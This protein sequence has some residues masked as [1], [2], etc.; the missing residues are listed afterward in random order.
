MTTEINTNNHSMAYSFT[1]INCKQKLNMKKVIQLI[2]WYYVFE[3]SQICLTLIR[4]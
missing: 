2:N 4:I 3:G 1:S